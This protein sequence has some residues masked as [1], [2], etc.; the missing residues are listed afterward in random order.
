M[1]IGLLI[2]G[3]G[4]AWLVGWLVEKAV[5]VRQPAVVLRPG[6]GSP[7]SAW[8]LE[9]T[10]LIVNLLAFLGGVT[11]VGFVLKEVGLRSIGALLLPLAFLMVCDIGVA[12][13]EIACGVACACGRPAYSSSDRSIR[14]RG[15]V[16]G[17]VAV[18]MT[19]LTLALS[20]CV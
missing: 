4:I 3:C 8:L 9:G 17:T 18:T 14:L 5:V 12:V 15:V 19:G 7:R 11:A 16:R 10:A 20:V 1:K 6:P 13:L 2:L